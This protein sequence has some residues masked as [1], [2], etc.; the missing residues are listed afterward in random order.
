MNEPLIMYTLAEAAKKY[1]VA[2]FALRRWTRPDGPLPCV[3]TG[4]K[5]LVAAQNVERFLLEGN[6]QPEPEMIST[7]QIRRLG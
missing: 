7:G 5:I 4:R 2:V 6:N 3:K 1:G